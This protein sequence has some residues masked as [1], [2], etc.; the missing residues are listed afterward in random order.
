MK[1]NPYLLLLLIAGSAAIMNMLPWAGPLGRAASVLDVNVTELWRPLIPVQV[2]GMVLMLFLA[3]LLGYREKK[4]IERQHGAIDVDFLEE[5]SE[6]EPEKESPKLFWFNAILTVLV[7]AVLVWG[8]IPAGFAFMIGVSIALPINYRSVD[9]QN[10]SIKTHAGSALTMGTIILGAGAFLGILTGTGMLDSIALD[11][12]KVIPE[13]ISSYIHLIIGVLGMPFDLLL[14]TDA[15]YFALLPVA[16]QIGL[17]FG[18]SSLATTYAMIIGNIV[19]TFVSPFSPALWLAL[20]LAG[21]EMGK[22]IR[23][24]FFWLWGISIALLIVGLLLGLI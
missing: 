17:T 21:L 22:H 8:V 18:I 2:I 12:V 4:R 9:E 5:A 15:Y 20:G 7:I 19:G 24:S 10:D 16:E 23:Y 11:T 3:F 6:T 13:A 1:M 14:S